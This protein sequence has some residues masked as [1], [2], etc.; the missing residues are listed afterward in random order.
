MTKQEKLQKIAEINALEIPVKEKL[1]RIKTFLV[2]AKKEED[3]TP[4]KE[5]VSALEKLNSNPQFI[6][7]LKGEDGEDGEDGHTP[8]D[9]ELL[10]LI[11]PLI[12]K[13]KDG[14]TPTTAEL[15]K[16]IKPL[17]P[18]VKDGETPS[19]ERIIELIKKSVP[20]QKEFV[21]EG[22]KIVEKINALEI[23]PEKQ[24]DASHIRNLPKEVSKHTVGFQRNVAWFDETTLVVDNPTR[25][26]LTG[27]GVQATMD[28]DGM[29]VITVSGGA[30]ATE[31][32]E[33]A[34]NS[35]DSTTFT[36]LNTPNAG[37]L[38]VY[39]ENTGQIYSPSNYTNTT[40]SIIFNSSLAVDGETPVVRAKYAY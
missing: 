14:K 4:I 34:T 24:I 13:V 33:I 28:A 12:P 3:T 30:A 1:E 29:L 10:A 22:E 38:L 9:E 21:L 11:K 20:E 2:E 37:T 6:P 25:I 27:A 8:T 15:F 40:T 35:G 18:E 26:K 5:V 19:D 39:N 16:I 17:I 31:T 36:I 23:E 7:V 32:D